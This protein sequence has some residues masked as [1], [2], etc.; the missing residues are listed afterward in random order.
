MEKFDLGVFEEKKNVILG[1]IHSK[2]G[3]CDFIAISFQRHGFVTLFDDG[4][5][6]DDV[7]KK[8]EEE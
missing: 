7:M 4:D 6:E 1:S 2:F 3:C 5:N 8:G